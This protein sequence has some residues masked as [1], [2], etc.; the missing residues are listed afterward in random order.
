MFESIVA[1]IAS[2]AGLGALISMLVN[3]G[4]AL[5]WIKDGDGDKAFKVISLVGF[6]AVAVVTIFFEAFDQWGEVDA[7]LQLVS[8]VIGFVLQIW[9]GQKTYEVTRGTPIIGF[10]HSYNAEHA[11]G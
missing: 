10:S 1:I 5:G 6:I 7:I 4:K 11:K 3:V 8:V 9:A 2:M